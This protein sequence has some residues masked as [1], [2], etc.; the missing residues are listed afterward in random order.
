M[1][2]L[3][4]Q[5]LEVLLQI[6]QDSLEQKLIVLTAIEQKSKEQSV[7]V[8]NPDVALE[9]IDKN[10]EDKSKLIDK[11]TRLDGGFETLYEN[12]RKNLQDKK[13]AYKPQIA[14]I[15]DLISKVM[16]KSASIE[17]IEARNKT[18]I[19]GIFRNRKKELQHRKNVSTVAR[20]YYKS[21][22]KLNVIPPQ[23]LDKKK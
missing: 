3:Q 11:L 16:E 2:N 17:V 6:L 9:A 15:Q 22:N 10:M 23:F 4:Q 7:I 21:A 18:A 14:K 5:P 19:E 13:D 12:I 8:A 20:Q 1:E